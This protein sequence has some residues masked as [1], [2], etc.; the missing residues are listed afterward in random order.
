MSIKKYTIALSFVVFSFFGFI[1][2]VSASCSLQSLKECDRA[3]LRSVIMDLIKSKQLNNRADLTKFKAT[4]IVSNN[5]PNSIEFWT[6]AY[7]PASGTKY[8]YD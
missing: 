5:L 4:E 7:C 6:Q 1:S 3:G 8:D 2:L